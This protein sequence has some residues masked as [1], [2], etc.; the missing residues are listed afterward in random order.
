MTSLYR[1]VHDWKGGT[2]EHFVQL[3]T[4][5][6]TMDLLVFDQRGTGKSTLLQDR[7]HYFMDAY[8]DDVKAVLDAAG[9]CSSSSISSS[10]QDGLGGIRSSSSSSSGGNGDCGTSVNVDS[11]TDINSKR[12]VNVVG[13]GFGGMVAQ[14]VCVQFPLAVKSISLL[15][16]A[17]GGKGGTIFPPKLQKEASH[18]SIASV[19]EAAL[20]MASEIALGD[21]RSEQISGDIV[22]TLAARILESRLLEKRRISS[23]APRSTSAIGADSGP[24]SIPSFSMPGDAVLAIKH[25]KAS[26]TAWCRQGTGDS[27]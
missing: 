7:S 11:S 8:V 10:S 17:T 15:G 13:Y 14:E 24:I 5:T 20:F 18:L 2:L 19:S 22:D 26:Q 12:K 27:Y 4:W 3:D 25:T 16:T 1:R 6:E 9:W 23:A 21:S